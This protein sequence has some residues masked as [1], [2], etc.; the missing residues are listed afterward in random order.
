MYIHDTSFTLYF[1]LTQNLIYG[2]HIDFDSFFFFNFISHRCRHTCS[3]STWEYGTD[4][5]SFLWYAIS[6]K[7]CHVSNLHMESIP[8]DAK[9]KWGFEQTTTTTIGNGLNA[10]PNA[11][12]HPFILMHSCIHVLVS[13]LLVIVR[14]QFRCISLTRCQ[15]LVASIYFACDAMPSQL[16]LHFWNGWE[17]DSSIFTRCSIQNAAITSIHAAV[18]NR[19][20]NFMFIWYLRAFA[21]PLEPKNGENKKQRTI[22]ESVLKSIKQM[23]VTNIITWETYPK[24][25]MLT[26]NNLAL[27]CQ[28]Q[29]NGIRKTRNTKYM[30]KWNFK[31]E[32]EK[33]K[34]RKRKEERKREML[35]TRVP[36]LFARNSIVNI[37]LWQN[38]LNKWLEIRVE[39]ISFNNAH[40]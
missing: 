30:D 28:R 33:K 35:R 3:H 32:S 15:T 16:P 18:R 27:A 22:I 4:V 7:C 11:D 13:H 17:L 21:D 12:V 36:W 10:L 29:W 26:Y 20:W 39:N 9:D 38:H 14:S 25:L 40:Y 5:R 19:R 37:V 8:R 23:N 1:T 6:Y 34:V 24:L 31:S 2:F